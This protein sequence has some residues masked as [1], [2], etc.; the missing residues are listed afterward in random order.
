MTISP[1]FAVLAVVLALA[2]ALFDWKSGEVPNWLTLGPLPFA[3]L[4]HAAAAGPHDGAF[5]IAAAPFCALVSLVGAVACSVVP[6]VMYRFALLG[7]A[8]VKLLASLG[9]LLM[10]RLGVEAELAGLL[11]GGFFALA[12]LAY[13]GRLLVTLGRN[14]LFLVHALGPAKRRKQLPEPMLD[15][16]RLCPF[17]FLGTTLVVLLRNSGALGQ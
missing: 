2:A 16:I 11:L 12:R 13:Q 7:G 17:L 5:G 4:A 8:D 6:L 14:V 10:P 15:S 9:A 3:V 1:A